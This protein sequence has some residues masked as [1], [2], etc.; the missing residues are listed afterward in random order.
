MKTPSSLRSAC[1][2]LTHTNEDERMM[3]RITSFTPGSTST[4]KL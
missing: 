2:L 3:A 4:A 1:T